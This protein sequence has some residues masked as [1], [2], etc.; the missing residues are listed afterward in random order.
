MMTAN[1]AMEA[2]VTPNGD[3]KKAYLG[4]L[5]SLAH[6]EVCVATAAQCCVLHPAACLT[7]TPFLSLHH[8]RFVIRSSSTACGVILVSFGQAC[9]GP[10]A[11]PTWGKASFLS[12]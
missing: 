11:S 5:G 9:A 7:D 8:P 3:V 10:I 2:I 12:M 6:V 4:Q 1:K